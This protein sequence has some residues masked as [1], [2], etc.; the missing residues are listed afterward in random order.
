MHR[1]KGE[2]T[3]LRFLEAAER[4]MR[5]KGLAKVT[6]KV[7]AQEA[8]YSEATLYLYFKC[9]EDLFLAVIYRHISIQKDVVP[10]VQKSVS[11]HLAEIS[12]AAM[13]SYRETVA[14]IACFFADVELLTRHQEIMHFL[15]EAPE[16]VYAQIARYIEAEQRL[17][18]ISLQTDPH[19]CAALLL[20]ACFH[21]A[22]FSQFLGERLLEITDQQ[23]VE[24]LVRMLIMGIDRGEGELF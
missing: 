11:A 22:F 12:L 7:I 14:L 5:A 4:L 8:G 19:S 16:S 17:H 10:N 6:T 13:T 2:Q 20:G 1:K 9:K 15:R 23:F 24:R 18:R 21:Y 3:R